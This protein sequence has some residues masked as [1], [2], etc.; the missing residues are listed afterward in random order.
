MKLQYTISDFEDSFYEDLMGLF[1]SL[2]T[3]EDLVVT[4]EITNPDTGETYEYETLVN[5]KTGLNNELTYTF[6]GYTWSASGMEGGV[7]EE[8]M[9]RLFSGSLNPFRFSDNTLDHLVRSYDTYLD[10]PSSGDEY[11][12]VSRLDSS[13]NL[14]N[15]SSYVMSYNVITPH[16][17]TPFYLEETGENTPPLIIIPPEPTT[18]GDDVITGSVIGDTI[19]GLE[20]NDI[21]TGGAGND[22]IQGDAAIDV[23]SLLASSYIWL[24]AQ[25]GA[26]LNTSVD[27][28][29]ITS[30]VNQGTGGTT[31]TP[32]RNTGTLTYENS[33]GYGYVEFGNNDF[34]VTTLT[35]NTVEYTKFI[36]GQ[37]YNTGS[38]ENFIAS[39]GTSDGH[40]IWV[41]HGNYAAGHE[42]PYGAV[43]E[44]NVDT[45][46][47][48]GTVRYDSNITTLELFRDGALVDSDAAIDGFTDD[49]ISIGSVSDAWSNTTLDGLIGEALVFNTALSDAQIDAINAYLGAKWDFST[50]TILSYDDVLYGD[51]GNDIL[52][53]Q[54]GADELWGGSGADTF[55]FEKDSAYDDID[56]IKDF[57]VNEHDALDLSDLLD[58]YDPMGD[59]IAD[60]I[61]L[62]EVGGNTTV[63]VDNDGAGSGDGMEAI[64]VLEGFVGLDLNDM[65]ADNNLI[66]S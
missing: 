13:D 38:W 2:P 4:Y 41:D 23:A 18:S 22:I 55:V 14:L 34:F 54:L 1:E 17:E 63:N 49:S 46:P 15:D 11:E 44:S 33:S 10:R 3:D 57:D 7:A 31:L 26:S 21:I 66:I 52:S 50:S 60:F 62:T 28:A 27:E 8:L 5:A 35:I 36:I 20:G 16:A 29:A 64:V 24:D 19:Y 53:G 30:W 61:S 12:P 43:S 42:A 51:S 25:D 65:I 9:S 56:T 39:T 40:T 47:I 37:T 6:D 59:A 48:L 32:E 45:D 58:L